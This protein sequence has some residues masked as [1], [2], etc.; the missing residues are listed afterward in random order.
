MKR[1]KSFL[2]SFTCRVV[3]EYPDKKNIV[4]TMLRRV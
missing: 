3:C 1:E 4:E 2:A